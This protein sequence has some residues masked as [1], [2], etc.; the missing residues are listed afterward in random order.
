VKEFLSQN[1]IKY[2]YVDIT[3]NMLFLKM[4]LK[5]RD[6]RPEFD[7]IKKAGKVGIP[8]IVVNDGEK[9][10]FDVPDLEELR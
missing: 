3:S 9:I 6:F 5:Y 7:E 8:M 2:N 1:E 10:F 4:Y